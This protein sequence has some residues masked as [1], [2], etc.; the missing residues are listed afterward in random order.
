M[1]YFML[2]FAL[3][4]SDIDVENAEPLWVLNTQAECQQVADIL[5]SNSEDEYVFCAVTE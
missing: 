4:A 2:M 1:N 3:S 5:N